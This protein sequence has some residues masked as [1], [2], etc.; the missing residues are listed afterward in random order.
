[1]SRYNQKVKRTVETVTNHQGGTGVKYD[2][3]LELIA[4]LTTG[5]DNSYY[6]KLSDRENRFIQLI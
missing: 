5:L 4:I 1:M 6:E 3:K 2:P